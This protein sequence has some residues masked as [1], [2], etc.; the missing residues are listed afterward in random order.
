MKLVLILGCSVALNVSLGIAYCHKPVPPPSRSEP[1][2]EDVPS[3]DPPVRVIE[4]AVP[5]VVTVAKA[6][7]PFDWRTVESD[8][9]KQYV[10]NLRA[11]GCPEKTLRDLIVADVNDLYRQRAKGLTT[12]RFE[13]WK[14]GLLGNAFDE[15]RVAQQQEQAK[16]RRDILA[17]LL[18][19]SYSDKADVTGGQII[20]PMEQMT[21]DFLSSD[22]QAAMKALE[23]KYANHM[24]RAAKDMSGHD[25]QAMRTVL[26]DKDA[27][28]LT[29][30]SP[31]EKLEYDLRLS[32]QAIMLR[33]NMGEFE[34]TEQEFR[35]MFKSAKK[36]TDQF[37]LAVLTHPGEAGPTG[38]A[39]NEMMNEFKNTLGEQRFQEFQKQGARAT[40]PK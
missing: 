40:P 29:H 39:A 4:K 22:Q 6:A 11:I 28:I 33:M 26:A 24:M 20:S 27:E 15:K 37:G 19:E 32:Q 16:E 38:S 7:A 17:S 5:N 14:P 1:Q 10:A 25:G 34:P 8:D 2:V 35:D 18:G 30:L 3:S 9:Y 21:G 36:F 31:E 12:N 13:Y 23:V